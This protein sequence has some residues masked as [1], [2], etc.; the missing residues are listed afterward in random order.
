[1]DNDNNHTILDQFSEYHA[2]YQRAWFDLY[3]ALE[4]SKDLRPKIQTAL[5]PH[6]G[7]LG[8]GDTTDPDQDVPAKQ[9]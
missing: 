7:Q 3:A 8:P 6:V 2:I 4:A 5:P 9:E 1:M